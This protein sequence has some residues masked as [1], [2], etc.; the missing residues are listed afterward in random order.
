MRKYIFCLCILLCL[1]FLASCTPAS[2]L[3]PS[4]Y[5]EAFRE[6]NEILFDNTDCDHDLI[7]SHINGK[8]DA[9][10]SALY[11]ETSCKWGNCDYEAHRTPHVFSFSPD[12]LPTARAHYKEN[13]Y[14][15]HSF[16]QACEECNG[17]VTVHVLCRTQDAEC[18]AGTGTIHAP[19]Q[20]FIGC[21]WNV[22]FADTPYRIIMKSDK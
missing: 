8:A 5:G 7:H 18:G 13:G 20:C 19:A 22:L 9:S 6:N 11:H 10:V 2:H 1:S 17:T 16:N 21:D 14:L 3:T 12:E 15:Y 4:D